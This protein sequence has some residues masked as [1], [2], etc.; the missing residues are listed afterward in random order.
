MQP[1]ISA[2]N[3]LVTGGGGYLGAVLVPLLLQL[4]HRVQVLDCFYFG[5]ESLTAVKMHPGLTIVR[6]DIFHQENIPNLLQGVDAII[7]LASLS[8]DP[9]CDLDPNLSIRTNFLATVALARRAKMEGVRQFIFASSCS[10]YGAGGHSWLN[11]TS[12][13]GPVTI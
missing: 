2:R 7:H 9:S 10:V 11:E 12:Q 8:N 1:N 13:T 3:I 6:E 4:G 5:E